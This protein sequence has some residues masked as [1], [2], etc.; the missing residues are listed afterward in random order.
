MFLSKFS[1]NIDHEFK[2]TLLSLLMN[3]KLD[4]ASA[5]FHG[6]KNNWHQMGLMLKAMLEQVW[7]FKI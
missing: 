5:I 3:F 4:K 6:Y 7:F 2:I 1:E